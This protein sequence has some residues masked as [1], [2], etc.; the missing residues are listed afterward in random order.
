MVQ[1]I[2]AQNAALLV[3]IETTTGTDAAPTAT[4]AVL[5]EVDGLTTTIGNRLI[6]ST[7]ATGSLD[8]GA[9]SPTGA[10]SQMAFSARIRGAGSAYTGSVRPPLHPVLRAC[11][12]KDTLYAAI[13]GAALTAGTATTATLGT[14]FSTTEQDYRG[15]VLTFTAG[16]HAG[17]ATICTDYTT[18]KVATLT[19]TFSPALTTTDSVALPAQVVYKPVSDDA[20]IP[21]VTIYLYVDGLV[22]RFVGM[23]GSGQFSWPSGQPGRATF[24]MTGEFVELDDEA[25]PTGI[26]PVSISAPLF[27]ME[28]RTYP[29]FLVDRLERAVATVNWDLGADI[30]SPEDPN[31]QFGFG[32]GFLV[33]RDMRVSIDPLM[34]L[35]AEGGNSIAKLQAG[36]LQTGALHTG[37]TAGNR[38]AAGWP[39][40]QIVERGE[41]ERTSLKAETLTMKANGANS[42]GFLA[43]W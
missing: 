22:Y 6:D 4:D 1:V 33:R 7:E 41:S 34:R 25:I 8:V 26:A 23:R 29:A 24:N 11:G 42:G 18:G 31:T 2:R 9:P 35:V 39:S 3:K 36:T 10:P 37:G 14:G 32:P 21:S 16:D 40:L 5:I 15:A 20:D 38:I 13:S 27:A 17:K 43:F 28:S 12:L 19:D 30:Q